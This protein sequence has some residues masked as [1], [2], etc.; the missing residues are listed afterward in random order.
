M[1]SSTTSIPRN[2][3]LSATVVG[4]SLVLGLA[5]E[6]AAAREPVTSPHEVKVFR[7]SL[8]FKWFDGTPV[9]RTRPGKNNANYYDDLKEVGERV[10]ATVELENRYLRVAVVP[11]AGGFVGRA[12]YKP[13]G[14]DMFVLNS[15]TDPSHCGWFIG[16][17]ASFPYREL[18]IRADQPAGHI[19]VENED[20]STTVAMWMEFS[21]YDGPWNARMYRRYSPM[22]LSQHITLQPNTSVFSATYRITNPTPYRMRRQLWNTACYPRHH[23][24]ERVVHGGAPLPER[25]TTEWIFPAAHVSGHSGR[26]FRPWTEEEIPLSARDKGGAS[27]FGWAMPY[28]FSGLWYPDVKVNRLRI[29]DP[30]IAPGAK[31]YDA[32]KVPGPFYVELWGGTDS[33][34]EEVENQLEPGEAWGFTAQYAMIAGIGKVDYANER[35]AVNVEPGATTVVEVVTYAPVSNLTVT[36]DGK[37]VGESRPCGPEHPLRVSMRSPAKKLTVRLLDDGEEILSRTLP[38]VIEPNEEQ[39]EIVRKALKNELFPGGPVPRAATQIAHGRLADAV[40]TLNRVTEEDPGNG[41]AWHLLG[42]ALLEQNDAA[43]GR[44]FEKA[45]RAEQPYA[46]AGYYLAL[47][48]LLGGDLRAAAGQLERLVEERPNHWEARLLLAWVA[49]QRG[50]KGI[51]TVRDLIREDPADPRARYILWVA[52][53]GAGD[54]ALAAGAKAALDALL[55][56]PWAARRLSEFQAATRGVYL[57]PNRMKHAAGWRQYR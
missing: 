32:G 26:K 39:Y 3:P 33:V 54:K 6:A 38:L 48:E 25:V 45:L 51:A 52:A 11:E 44:A 13:T 8:K 14:D 47:T 41:E 56:E 5:G 29:V 15:R 30:A 31:Q 50:E 37:P 17:K 46:P 53:A 34:F 18:G 16:L 19:V 55:E 4:V 27:V 22:V 24:K 43:A 23:T 57:A 28:A 9:Y 1:T 40:Q 35:A 12:L 42:A 36:I 2:G 49:T 7:D 10:F 20:G 21:R